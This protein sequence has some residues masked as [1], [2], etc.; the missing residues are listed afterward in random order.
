MKKALGLLLTLALATAACG[1]GA[2]TDP[3]A[4]KSCDEL[5]DVGINV[6]QDALD[7]VSG[8][9]VDDLMDMTDLPPAISLLETIDFDT[10]ADTLGCSDDA[11]ETLSCDKI[12]NL[13]ADGA[14]AE[15]MLDGFS[16]GC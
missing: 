8:M 4:A 6:L 5:A 2:G 16:S 7:S 1:G 12:G 11:M 15:F 14:A 9:T 13:K 10:P 3:A